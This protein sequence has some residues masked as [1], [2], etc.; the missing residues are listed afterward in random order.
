MRRDLSDDEFERSLS[1]A[2]HSLWR[3]EQQPAYWVGYERQQFDEFLAGRPRP[4]TE[5][6]D[7]AN[8]MNQ[9]AE[10]T[11]QGMTIGRVRIVDDPITDYQRWMRWMD[12]WNRAAGEVIDYLGRPRLDRI[13]PPPFAPAADWWFVDEER[14]VIMHFDGTYRRVGAEVLVDEPEIKLA[15]RWRDVVIAEARAAR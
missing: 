6:P 10:Q 9:V 3:W 2:R 14:L 13:G 15:G 8:W 12:R 7:L 5:A 1:I 4:P 11:G